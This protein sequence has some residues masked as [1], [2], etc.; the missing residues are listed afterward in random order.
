MDLKEDAVN[1]M[2]V[3]TKRIIKENIGTSSF[4]S[5]FVLTVTLTA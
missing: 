1:V 2:Y 4:I 5:R 3:T